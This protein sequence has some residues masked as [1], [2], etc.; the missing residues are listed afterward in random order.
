MHENVFSNTKNQAQGPVLSVVHKVHADANNSR[1]LDVPQSR[2][3]KRVYN[4]NLFYP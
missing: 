3:L 4:T 1:N 2:T